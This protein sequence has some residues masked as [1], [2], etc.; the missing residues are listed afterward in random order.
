MKFFIDQ[1][2]RLAAVTIFFTVGYAT[3]LSLLSNP[4]WKWYDLIA[5][6][7]FLYM[8]ISLAFFRSDAAL[9]RELDSWLRA[10]KRWFGD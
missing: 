8:A 10:I 5:A 7:P 2:F 9:V 6:G 4:S 3:C 1:A